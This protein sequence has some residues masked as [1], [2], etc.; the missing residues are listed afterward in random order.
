M[1]TADDQ[2]LPRIRFLSRL[3]QWLQI[4]SN[5]RYLLSFFIISC[6][7][8]KN[9]P[10]YDPETLVS[11]L[12]PFWID[13][14]AKNGR[15]RAWTFHA[16]RPEPELI[17]KG[18]QGETQSENRFTASKRNDRVDRLLRQKE[19][20][21]VQVLLPHLPQILQSH[22]SEWLLWQLRVQTLHQAHVQAVY[23]RKRLYAQ[24]PSLHS[25]SF[26]T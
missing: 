10:G 20:P 16:S 13:M 12:N 4:P 25:T 8:T 9:T 1:D 19:K 5:N 22:L 15:W 18:F 21:W 26:Q 3:A 17:N 14:K 11:L 24:M 2:G 23:L 7:R 6:W